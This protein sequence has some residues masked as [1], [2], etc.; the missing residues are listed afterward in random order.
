LPIRPYLGSRVFEPE[1]IAAMGEAFEM[2]CRA[3]SLQPSKPD[4]ATA[5]VAEAVITAAKL[6]ATDQKSMFEHTLALL[7]VINNGSSSELV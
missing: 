3:L 5:R 1:L 2:T 6:G 4:A 7:G